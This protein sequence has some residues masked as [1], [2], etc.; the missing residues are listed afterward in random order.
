MTEGYDGI[1]NAETA[2]N[3]GKAIG[4]FNQVA[5]PFLTKY[6][7]KLPSVKLGIADLSDTTQ[8]IYNSSYDAN[9]MG[10]AGKRGSWWYRG[11]YSGEFHVACTDRDTKQE[12]I[13][14]W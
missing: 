12:Y 4:T 9:I 1:T 2:A 3:E 11:S 5:G 13:T 6:L 14:A 10:T 7:D 8:T